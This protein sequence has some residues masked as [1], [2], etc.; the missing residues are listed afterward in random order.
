MMPPAARHGHSGLASVDEEPSLSAA[1]NHDCKASRRAWLQTSG[2]LA[3]PRRHH[4]GA[5]KSIARE[6]KKKEGQ[7]RL[8]CQYRR[9][10]AC[11]FSPTPQWRGRFCR[12]LALVD[13]LG[14]TAGRRGLCRV[15]YLHA[16][17]LQAARAGVS[18]SPARAQRAGGERGRGRARASGWARGQRAAASGNASRLCDGMFAVDAVECSVQCSRYTIYVG[19][20]VPLTWVCRV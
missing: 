11:C 4:D 2:A 7:Q 1:W 16:V 18:G 19:P 13:A 10:V 15:Q 12:K 5:G 8:L 20:Q 6:G 17:V 14:I 3:R 9:V